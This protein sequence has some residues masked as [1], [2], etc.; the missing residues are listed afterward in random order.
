MFASSLSKSQPPQGAMSHEL[1]FFV[2][3]V[4]A[5]CLGY[6][7]FLALADWVFVYNGV[8][9]HR[10]FRRL[11][12]VTAETALG[13]W[14][15][16]TQAFVIGCVALL[17]A[18]KCKLQSKSRFVIFSWIFIGLFFVYLSTDDA[19]KIH[20]RTSPFIRHKLEVA[21]I[22]LSDFHPSYS[23]LALF[24]PVFSMVG[25]FIMY[26]LW[27]ELRNLSSYLLIV[28][29]IGVMMIAVILDF[30]EGLDPSHSL[31]LVQDVQNIFQLNRYWTVHLF[32]LVEEIFEM[33]SMT[34]F[35]FVFLMHLCSGVT[36]I[37]VKF[38]DEKV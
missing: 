5:F 8:I 36:S 14:F 32:R 13:T 23:W 7:L 31:Y 30:I 38:A 6:E 2:Y 15:S 35:L 4:T 9:D 37:S 19:A 28:G 26:F 24:F 3:S 25:L 1:K 20:E 17:I 27:R 18:F 12:D 34:G 21:G 22:M 11:F 16:V 29:S 10:G 33:L